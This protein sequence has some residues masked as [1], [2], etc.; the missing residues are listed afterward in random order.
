MKNIQYLLHLYQMNLILK[1]LNLYQN[2][3]V[4]KIFLNQNDYKLHHHHQHQQQVFL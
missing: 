4:V 2:E 1:K 3:I